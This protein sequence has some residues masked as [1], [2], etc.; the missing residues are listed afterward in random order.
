M[1][2]RQRWHAHLALVLVAY[3]VGC[4]DIK[5]KTDFDQTADFSKFQTFAFAGMTDLNQNGVLANSLV[6][7]RIETAIARELT[8]RAVSQVGLNQNPDLLV[9]DRMGV[10]DKQQIDTMGPSMG[11]YGWHGR[12]GYGGGYGGG[13]YGG[14]GYGGVTSYEYQEGTLIMDL[15][16]PTGKQLVWRAYRGGE[17]GGHHG[18]QHRSWAMKPLPRHLRSTRP[19][20]LSDGA[21][22]HV[23]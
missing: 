22:L 18:R 9:H 11:A 2:T 15:I 8:K 16:E 1:R 21:I 23:C 10:K 5:V 17:F 7:K 20:R 19:P 12:Y 3:V 14:G 13:G 6:R 4:T